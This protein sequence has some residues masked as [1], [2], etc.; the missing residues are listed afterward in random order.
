MRSRWKHPRCL[1]ADIEI[2][3][4]GP[5][6]QTRLGIAWYDRGV[7]VRT[8]ILAAA[9][10][11]VE[12]LPGCLHAQLSS[13]YQG[14]AGRVGYL[15]KEMEWSG[16]WGSLAPSLLERRWMSYVRLAVHGTAP[17]R[18]TPTAAR[19]GR[20]DELNHYPRLSEWV[21]SSL[22]LAAKGSNAARRAIHQDA[23]GA[24]L[25]VTRVDLVIGIRSLIKAVLQAKGGKREAWCKWCFTAE[26]A[27]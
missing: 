5:Q 25:H 18:R 1:G 16:F 13:G 14:S 12:I 23:V 17:E 10:V 11:D 20:R 19:R 22:V 9:S 6:M 4:Y 21:V 24:R 7:E 8:V 15:V 3:D 26:R 2:G 27:A